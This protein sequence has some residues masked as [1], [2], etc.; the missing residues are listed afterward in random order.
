MLCHSDEELLARGLELNDGLQIV[1]AKH[2][3][4]ASGSPLPN[5]TANFNSQLDKAG[6]SGIKQGE[7]KQS[8]KKR[9]AS[10]RANAAPSTPP[11][12][13]ASRFI[14]EEDEEEDDFAQL[15]RRSADSRTLNNRWH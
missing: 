5:Q 1:L 6:A 9:D 2:D 3:S 10:P 13:L 15:A 4:I 11:A 14:D 12:T 8:E 7:V